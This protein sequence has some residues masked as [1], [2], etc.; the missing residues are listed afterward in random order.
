MHHNNS[1]VVLHLFP[2]HDSDKVSG[3][4]SRKYPNYATSGY[5]GSVKYLFDLF[6]NIKCLQTPNSYVSIGCKMALV[7][8][9]YCALR[10]RSDSINKYGTLNRGET[11]LFLDGISNPFELLF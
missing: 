10:M 6:A 7:Y 9:V 2:H 3:A 1:W 11:P 4:A 8:L 5:T